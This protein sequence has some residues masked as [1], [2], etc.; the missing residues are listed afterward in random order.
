[1]FLNPDLHALSGTMYSKYVSHTEIPCL[2]L[3]DLKDAHKKPPKNH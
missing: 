1:M 2:N 3:N